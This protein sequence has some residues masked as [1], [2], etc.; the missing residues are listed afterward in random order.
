M[1]VEYYTI[2]ISQVCENTIVIYTGDQGFYLGEHGLYNKRFMYEEG[3][4]MPFLIRWPER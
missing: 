2:W 4:R 1:W 3:L